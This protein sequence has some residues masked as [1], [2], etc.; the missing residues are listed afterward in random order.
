MP[1]AIILIIYTIS[2]CTLL[3]ELWAYINANKNVTI[4]WA[5]SHILLAFIPIFNTLFATLFAMLTIINLKFWNTP[6]RK[7][8]EQS[9]L[10]DDL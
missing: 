5:V 6:L 9:R 4:G 1:I 8:K 10:Q 3:I 7:Q 2:T